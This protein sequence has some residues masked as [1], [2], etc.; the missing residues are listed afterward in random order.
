MYAIT[1]QDYWGS[2]DD[3]RYCVEI[4]T[5]GLDYANADALAG[6]YPGEFDVYEDPREALDVA[7]EI[8]K[9]WQ[10]DQPD[11]IVNISHGFTGGMSMPFEPSDEDELKEWAQK[12]YDKLPK[13]ARCGGVIKEAW[14]NPHSA[15]TGFEFDSE[16][17]A[18]QD[19]FD[20]L[21]EEEKL[22]QEQE[23]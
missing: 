6:K 16:Y 12:E 10:K 5:G 2:E 7:I 15:F 11:I 20:N 17:C 19:Y 18:D 4:A 21:E 14:F 13:C 23:D 9:A 22:E 8:A 3:E 1:R